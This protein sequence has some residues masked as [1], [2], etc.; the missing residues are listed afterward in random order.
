MSLV[1]LKSASCKLRAVCEI[2]HQNDD[3]YQVDSVAEVLVRMLEGLRKEEG[4]NIGVGWLE[5]AA[6]GER[7][8]ECWQKY[9]CEGQGQG[10]SFSEVR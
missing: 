8:E 10:N 5:A 3:V 1:G 6:R 4:E 9:P 7:G 2:H